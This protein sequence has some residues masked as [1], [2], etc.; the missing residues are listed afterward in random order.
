LIKQSQCGCL[1]KSSTEKSYPTSSTHA[2]KTSS[3]VSNYSRY[4]PGVPIPPNVL[5]VPDIKE[6]AKNAT[7]LIFVIP[8]QFLRKICKD[9]KGVIKKDCKAISLMKV[10][11]C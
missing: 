8:H 5:A 7:V 11:M 3:S 6:S 1:K 4:L 10:K 9:L 2:M